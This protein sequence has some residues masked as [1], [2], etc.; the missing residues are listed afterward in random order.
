MSNGSA[1]GGP[2]GA[3]NGSAAGGPGGV[4]SGSVVP[5]A[6]AS[7]TL[8]GSSG[9]SAANSSSATNLS[10]NALA[11][12]SSMELVS[13]SAMSRRLLHLPLKGVAS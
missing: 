9:G 7:A 10:T 5:I 12:I 2:R 1:V 11:K 3:S 13:S 4:E 6:K 8:S